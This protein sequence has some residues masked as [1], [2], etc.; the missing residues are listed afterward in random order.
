[1]SELTV[2]IITAEQSLL[3][4]AKASSV[5]APGVQGA[6]EVLPQHTTFLTEL[7]PGAVTVE[8]AEGTQRF[9]ISGGFAEVMLGHV[10]ILA[11][12]ASVAESGDGAGLEGA[13]QEI[14]A[15]LE[16]ADPYSSEAKELRKRQK[17]IEIQRQLQG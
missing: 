14:T 4:D 15:Q 1:M 10:R 5:S 6:F 7:E 9:V 8:G 13:L 17:Y 3:V 11:D 16:T 2:D 12:Q